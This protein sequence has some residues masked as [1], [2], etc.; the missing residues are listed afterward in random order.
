MKSFQAGRNHYPEHATGWIA[1]FSPETWKIAESIKYTHA[2][3]PPHRLRQARRMREGDLI[4]PYITKD[5]IFT[6]ILMASGGCFIDD[7][8]DLF[9]PAGTY[10]IVLPVAPYLV[11][12]D[13]E[14]VPASSLLADLKIFYG[15]RSMKS[16]Y[17]VLRNSPLQLRTSDSR[18]L[19]SLLTTETDEDF[20]VN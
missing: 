12:S 5:R 9:A 6:G 20:S 4:F 16:P 11:L 14:A 13:S 7:T 8:S 17:G 1:I 15:A 18:A 19:F 3:F 2:A 10:S